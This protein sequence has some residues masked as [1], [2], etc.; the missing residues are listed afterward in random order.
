MLPTL[1]SGDVILYERMSVMFGTLSRG[2]IV[3]LV[4]PTKLRRFLGKRLIAM[5]GDDLLLVQKD[6]DEPGEECKSFN[7]IQK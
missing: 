6:D 4:E 7:C 3:G 1:H 5:A 2:D